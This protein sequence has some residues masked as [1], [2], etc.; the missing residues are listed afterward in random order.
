MS[1]KRLV[2]LILVI[3]LFFVHAVQ[4]AISPQ[5]RAALIALYNATNGDSWNNNSNW[6]NI[7]PEPDGFSQIGTEGTWYGI[8][9]QNNQV[10]K[11]ILLYN[12]LVGIIPSELGNL[13]GL[14]NLNLKNNQLSASIPGELG[15]LSNLENLYLNSNQLSS[16]IP[17][18]LGNL[19]TLKILYLNDNYLDGPIPTSLTNLNNLYATGLDIETNCLCA[20]DASLI[21]WLNTAD[22]D[23]Q[24]NQSQCT[25]FGITVT[26]PNGGENLTAG[27]TYYIIWTGPG[28]VCRVKIEYS[29]DNGSTWNTIINS[30]SNDGSYTWTVP[31]NPSTNCKVR[32]SDAAD[33][34]TTDTSDSKF[35]I[36]PNATAPTVTTNDIS[37]V[38]ST[39][40]SCGGNV[41]SDGGAAVT[42]RGVCWST[43]SNPTISNSKTA[44]GTGTGAFTSNITGLTPNTIYYVRAYATN[45]NGTSYGA[46]KSFTTPSTSSTYTF[47]VQSSPDTGV[48]ITVSPTDK[49]GNGNGTTNFTRIYSPG[50]IITLTA[51]ISFNGND[52]FKWTVDGNDYNDKTIQVTIDANRTA[53]AYYETPNPPEIGV[54]RTE[55]N[56]GYIIGSSVQPQETF[57]VFNSG[58]GTLNWTVSSEFIDFIMNPTSGTNCGVVTLIV[59]AAGLPPGKFDG[60]IYVSAP[61][62]HNSPMEIHVNLWV[63]PGAQSSPPFGDFST[64][65]DGSI[66][67]SSIPVTGWVLSDTGMESV[68]IYRQEGNSLIYIGDAIFVEGARP[69]IE[70]AFPGYP[71]NHKAGWGYMMLTNFLPNG[72]NGIYKIH[73][74]ATDREG[75]KT[76]LGSKTIFVDN[77][78]A[79]KP[80]GA[81]ETPGQGGTASG[82]RFAAQLYPRRR[83]HH[84]CLC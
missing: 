8:T 79:V 25:I 11:I 40:A 54:S 20:T 73:A 41:I 45:S 69:D 48:N 81:I 55:L 63:K 16:T 84:K 38:T 53:A 36:V 61:L 74:I 30:T 42:G 10:T 58:G 1:I 80:F 68:K 64:P 83:F 46:V 9:V 75:R 29:T 50:T 49:N 4:G 3:L 52:F 47:H 82:S 32:I 6:K 7:N 43:S 66:V 72:G 76:N 33:P 31:Y 39:S 35:S 56:L 34:T 21:S 14:D 27:S 62:A 2:L 71:M 26:T 44:N 51:P 13:N 57:T 28:N 70:A 78:N 18:E 23:W 65:A 22:P 60:V 37:S 15:N 5:E 12:N 24:T 19:T 17:G 77:A 59:E 67:R